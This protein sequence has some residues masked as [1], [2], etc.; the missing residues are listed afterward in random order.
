[1]AH[2][3]GP[4]QLMARLHEECRF[5]KEVTVHVA[6]GGTGM[7]KLLAHKPLCT[8]NEKHMLLANGTIVPRE[9]IHEKLAM[10]PNVTA[11]DWHTDGQ[12]VPDL[13]PTCLS[14][15]GPELLR[16]YAVTWKSEHELL[17]V[18]NSCPTFAVITSADSALIPQPMVQYNRVKKLLESRGLLNTPRKA[19]WF[20]D[21]RFKN[22]VIV[23]SDAGGKGNGSRFI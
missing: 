10:L 19:R 7:V 9:L 14:A 12:G 8:I 2:G 4:S 3:I 6:P 22:Q 16:A 18:D 21:V 20:A 23:F 1:M 13:L 17:L 5:I 15:L 11:N